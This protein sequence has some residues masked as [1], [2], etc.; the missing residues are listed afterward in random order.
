MTL[1][2]YNARRDENEPVLVELARKSGRFVTRLNG[3]GVPDLLLIKPGRELPV[4]IVRNAEQ[5]ADVLAAG[6][7]MALVE[8]KTATGGLT[9]RQK[10]WWLDAG[11]LDGVDG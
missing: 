5:M 8:V 6:D 3:E 7:D 1:N 9:T 2:R 4:Y 11:L 10:K